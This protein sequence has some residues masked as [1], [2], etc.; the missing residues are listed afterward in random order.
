MLKKSHVGKWLSA[1][2]LAFFEDA[3]T[4][5]TNA[6]AALGTTPV[7]FAASQTAFEA[8]LINLD[9]LFKTGAASAHSKKLLELDAKR[10]GLFTGV[11]L[12]VQSHT[13]HPDAEVRAAASLLELSINAYGRGLVRRPLADETAIIN[14]LLNDWKEKSSLVGALPAIAGLPAFVT[15]LTA[16]NTEFN[17][18]YLKRTTET[19]QEPG[20]TTEEA[21]A[22]TIAAYEAVL[23]KIK[24]Y[25]EVA[26]NPAPW[27]TL[28]SQL[29]AL[30]DKY[31]TNEA[32]REGHGAAAKAAAKPS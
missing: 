12:L 30:W 8:S 23:V 1:T 17:T 2:V 22:A 21:Q 29:S 15:A 19:A 4:L 31:E 7:T 6:M 20:F 27:K 26:E 9:S 11:R 3:K 24:G 5:I 28:L 13:Y 14:S 25:S 10:D 16:A 18:L 32:I